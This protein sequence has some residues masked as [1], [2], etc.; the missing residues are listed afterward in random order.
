MQETVIECAGG[1]R[2]LSITDANSKLFKGPSDLENH[3][4]EAPIRMKK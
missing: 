3:I 4:N 1:G 2:Q